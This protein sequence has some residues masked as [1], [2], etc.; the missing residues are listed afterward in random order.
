[1]HLTFELTVTDGGQLQSS[2]SCT[3]NILPVNKPPAANAGPDQTVN[4]GSTVTLNGSGSNDP[5]GDALTYKWTQISGPAVNL[6]NP[7][8]VKL[9]FSL[10]TGV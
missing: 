8:S 1:M 9:T 7:D 5:D 4:E 6:N 2:D 3:I 10:L